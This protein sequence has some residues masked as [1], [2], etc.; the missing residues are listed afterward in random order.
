VASDNASVVASDN[1]SV[2]AWDNAT[3]V[4]SG[5]A[6][7]VAW[8]N[9]YTICRTTIECKISGK[10]IVRRYDTNTIQFCDESLKFEKVE[11]MQ[12]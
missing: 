3:V 12:S 5:N 4:A 9:A 6:S 11:P 2:V 10:A 8:D 7:V 1:A